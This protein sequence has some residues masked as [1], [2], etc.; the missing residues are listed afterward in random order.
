MNV[1]TNQ[2]L[3]AVVC[4][5]VLLACPGPGPEMDAGSGGG[6][7]GGTVTGGGSGGGAMGGGTGG[8]DA[9]AGLDAGLDAGMDAGV[10]AGTDPC[11][12]I[13]HDVRL[14]TYTLATG[15]VVQQ[16]AALPA[17]ITQAA[18]V[19][20]TL[21]GLA[22][23]DTVKQLG[24][25][26]SFTTPTTLA[27]IRG[28]GDATTSIFA[29]AYL[30]VSGSKLLAGYSKMGAAGTVALIDTADAGVTYLNA[31]GNYD[32]TGAA[33]VGF[34]VNGIGL[35]TV[36]GA[37]AYALSAS[38]QAA[39]AF[40][41]FDAAWLGSGLIAA[42]TNGVALIGYYGSTPM[43]GNYVRAVAPATYAATVP[44]ALAP[45]VLVASPDATD[46]VLDL[47]SVGQDAVV[48]MGAFDANF[49]P[50]VSHVDRIAL[51]V[52]G[53]A[54]TAAAPVRLLSTTDT[55]SNV[56]FIQSNGPRLLVGIEDKN[57]RRLLDIQ[58]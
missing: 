5:V 57:G 22:S 31:P 17:G 54:V 39:T 16:T 36:T 1:K 51:T 38:T 44:F 46:D 58:P 32:A 6:T 30:A 49:T 29:S 42:T 33:T 19:G 37:G 10:D 4:A 9:D 21:F 13:A 2:M 52:N 3:F 11:D 34:L 56:L 23:D 48:A 43:A 40:A 45:E 20:P 7:G 50:R 28:P 26:P 53:M 8:G 35:G 27:S 14:G 15:A 55:C 18:A 41:N 25:F 47:A 24:A 12:S